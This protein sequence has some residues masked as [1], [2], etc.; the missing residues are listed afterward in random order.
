M[1]YKVQKPGDNMFNL[2]DKNKWER[3][4]HFE[5]FTTKIKCAYCCT[6]RL[7]VTRL[8]NLTEAKKIKFYPVFVYCVAKIVNSEKE[9][10]MGI[11]E[12]GLPG[13]FDISNPSMTIFHEHNHTFSDLWVEYYPNFKEFYDNAIY[14]IEKYKDF[15]CVKAR[16][17]IPPNF[18]SISCVPWLDFTGYATN[19]FGGQPNFFPIFTFGKYTLK[20]TE[21]HEKEVWEMP[22]NINIAHASADGYHTAKFIND[23]QHLLNTIEL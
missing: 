15:T 11:N 6:V 1:S 12:D 10:R 4:E 5:Y 20:H 18:F 21:S 22:F 16:T 8:K 7:D 23:L 19:S 3:S 17:N 9:F 14:H 2:F 13:Y